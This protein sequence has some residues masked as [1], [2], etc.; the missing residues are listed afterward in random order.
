M[1]KDLK[2][3]WSNDPEEIR[4]VLGPPDDPDDPELYIVQFDYVPKEK[5]NENNLR[6]IHNMNINVKR[7]IARK[8][9]KGI[10]N[11]KGHLI[12]DVMLPNDDNPEGNPIKDEG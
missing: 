4:K 6:L 9:A 10:Y 7:E 2:N 1:T 8:Q 3:F 11:E 12:K 5:E